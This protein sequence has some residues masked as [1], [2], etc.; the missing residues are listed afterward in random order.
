M[1]TLAYLIESQFQCVGVVAGGSCLQPKR[2]FDFAFDEPIFDLL[3]SLIYVV[4]FFEES[5]RRL[6][7]LAEQCINISLRHRNLLTSNPILI[8]EKRQER[9]R[10]SSPRLLSAQRSVVQ[11]G[12]ATTSSGTTCWLLYWN[13][14]SR[15][16]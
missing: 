13:R 6:R 14:T 7:K 11:S 3:E 10:S 2:Q 5:V 4:V 9:G 12:R 16:H 8:R 1:P 15:T